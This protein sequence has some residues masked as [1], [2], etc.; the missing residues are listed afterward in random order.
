MWVQSGIKNQNYIRMQKLVFFVIVMAVGMMSCE[1]KP[2]CEKKNYGTVTIQNDTDL[3]VWVDC[4]REGQDTNQKR[5]LGVDESAEYKMDAG[6]VEIK[7]LEGYDYP[8]GLWHD[9]SLQLDQ[10]SEPL[11]LLS[12]ANVQDSCEKYDFGTVIVT[13]HTGQAIWVDCTQE[14][15]DIN[16]ER[17][18][19]IGQS[20]I[21]YMKPGMVT[22]WAIEAWDY[23]AGSWYTDTYNLEQCQVYND[24]W[25]ASKSS[26]I[27]KPAKEA[28]KSEGRRKR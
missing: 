20:T 21:Y 16:E 8:D 27:S 18:L 23:P 1:Q 19:G 3:E 17:L 10:C 12:Q 5:L 22:E 14:G 25:T 6:E 11:Q 7:C 24:P 13:N 26:S 28:A 9:V 4:T 2:D 15:L